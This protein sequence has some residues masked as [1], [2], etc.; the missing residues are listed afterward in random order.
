M[1]LSSTCPSKPGTD[2]FLGRPGNLS[3]TI[4]PRT[5]SLLS[6]RET[7]WDKLHYMLYKYIKTFRLENCSPC[8][9]G[10]D[11]LAASSILHI[12]A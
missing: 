12:A 7:L 4:E 1:I 5:F 11:H 10:K 8:C 9:I 6:P 2:V 3:T